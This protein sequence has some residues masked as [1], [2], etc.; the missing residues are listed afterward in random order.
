[1]SVPAFFKKI[2]RLLLLLYEVMAEWLKRQTVN[3]L[4]DRRWFESNPLQIL[5]IS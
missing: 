5:N 2:L 1:M 4:G 3:L